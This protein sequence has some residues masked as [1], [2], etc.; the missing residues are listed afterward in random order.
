[1]SAAAGEKRAYPHPHVRADWL[2]LVREDIIEPALPIVDPHHHLWDDRPSGRYLLD[3]LL[4]DLASGH[5]VVATVFVECGAMYRADGPADCSPVGETEFVER[6]RGDE[7]QRPL[8]PTRACAGI[9]G[10]AD[11]TL[12]DRRRRR[13]GGASS[14]P[15]AGA[16]AASATSPPGTTTDRRPGASIAPQPGLY[17]DPTFR[18]GFAAWAR[19]VSPSTPGC[20]AAAPRLIDL[21]RAFP[22]T[23]IVLDH[24][25]SAARAAAPIGAA[26]GGFATGGRHDRAGQ[27]AERG[28]EARRPG[29][30]LL[31]LPL[32]DDARAAVSAALARS[33]GP[34]ETCIEAFGAERCMFESNFPVDMGMLQLRHLWNA[35]KRIAKGSSADEKAALF[36]DTAARFYN[37]PGVRAAAS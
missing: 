37:L 32:H 34:F 18:E 3:E 17:R 26:R 4:A 20:S 29:H 25:G 28:R 6:R 35:F 12:G 14:P 21:A 16:S 15:A 30:G 36:S 33:G 11:L 31:Q 22:E 5:N 13:A 8:R 23:T 10:H 24:V 1:M 7:R 27:P 19:W 9:V 2:D